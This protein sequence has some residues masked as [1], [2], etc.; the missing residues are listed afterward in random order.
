LNSRGLGNGAMAVGKREALSPW[1]W[2]YEFAWTALQVSPIDRS[3]TGSEGNL[4]RRER[5][6]SMGQTQPQARAIY[7]RLASGVA[8]GD[9]RI[10]LELGGRNE[11]TP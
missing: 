9:V 4:Q 10:D 7:L 11:D 8:S 2:D 3:R 6:G 5:P 1:S